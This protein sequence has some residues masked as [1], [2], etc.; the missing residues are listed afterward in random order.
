MAGRPPKKADRS[1]FVG[2]V[3]ARIRARRIER[4][5]SG[6]EA[7]KAAGVP[8]QTWYHWEKGDRLPLD[9][10]PAIARALKCREK[11]LV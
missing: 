11:D 2:R 4:K 1:T 6:Y 10:L 9:A 7:A 8:A 3:A 5:L